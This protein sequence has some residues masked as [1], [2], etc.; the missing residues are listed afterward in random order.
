MSTGLVG[1]LSADKM[2]SATATK[3]AKQSLRTTKLTIF[4][5]NTLQK[6][7]KS[8]QNPLIGH[9]FHFFGGRQWI[10]AQNLVSLQV[11][12]PVAD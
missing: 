8:S 11:V 5:V 9:F 6:A 10:I 12:A 3:W 2:L 4:F 1:P 7:S